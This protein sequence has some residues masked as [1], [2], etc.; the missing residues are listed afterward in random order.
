MV[1]TVGS[2]DHALALDVAGKTFS[3]EVKL[4]GA[5]CAVAV[6]IDGRLV[7]VG[8]SNG[9]TVVLAAE[10]STAVATFPSHAGCVFAVAFLGPDRVV[11]CGC[12]CLFLL[13]ACIPRADA[14]AVLWFVIFSPPVR[15]KSSRSTHCQKR[16]K[17]S[18]FAKLVTV[19]NC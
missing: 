15:T 11:T 6:S 5:A 14:H 16:P 17:P 7:A 1:A 10:S 18:R 13:G 9:S 19:F 2:S 12:G 4:P 8:L 3:E